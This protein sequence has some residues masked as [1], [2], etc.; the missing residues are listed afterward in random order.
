MEFLFLYETVLFTVA[1]TT[2]K[3]TSSHKR[4]YNKPFI[5]EVSIMKDTNKNILLYKQFIRISEITSNSHTT[6]Q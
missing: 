3:H 6:V 2:L 4:E 1:H 5:Q